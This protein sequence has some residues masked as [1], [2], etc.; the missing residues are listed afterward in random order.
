MHEM[1]I[2]LSVIDIASKEAQANG[3]T[4]IETIHLDVGKLAGV[5]IDSL[6]FCFEA[7][8]KDSMAAQAELKINE[9]AGRGKCQQCGTGFEVDTFVTICPECGGYRV[10]IEQ[11]RELRVASITVAD[12]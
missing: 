4:S 7:A 2:A 11:G 9:I 5:M 3:A 1:S 6:E 10:D 12:Q 8:R